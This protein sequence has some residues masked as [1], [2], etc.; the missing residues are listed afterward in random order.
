[1]GDVQQRLLVSDMLYKICHH[2]SSL[3]VIMSV[4]ISLVSHSLH[5]KHHYTLQYLI[6][7]ELISAY[8]Y[9]KEWYLRCKIHR[10]VCDS[11]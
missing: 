4:T 8:G 5:A 9:Q 11:I 7:A 10:K 1:M 6:L 3:A 2:M